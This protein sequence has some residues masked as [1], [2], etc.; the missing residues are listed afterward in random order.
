VMVFIWG[1]IFGTN[2]GDNGYC[3]AAGGGQYTDSSNGFTLA[4]GGLGGGGNSGHFSNN[5]K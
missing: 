4:L 3:A 5:N 2:L 1:H